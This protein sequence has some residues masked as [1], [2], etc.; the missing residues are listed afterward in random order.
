M[1]TNAVILAVVAILAIAV[2]EIIAIS[3]GIN[4]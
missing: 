2:L 1:N 3:Q 4:G